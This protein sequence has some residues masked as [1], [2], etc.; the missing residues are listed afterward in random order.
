MSSN[1]TIRAEHRNVRPGTLL[2]DVP[3]GAAKTADVQLSVVIV[4]YNCLPLLQT[5][6]ASLAHEAG[7]P[8]FET[9]VVDNGSL[10]STPG[11]LRENC[12][13]VHVIRN[14]S[15]L[16][17]AK[18]CNQGIGAALGQYVL[19]LN[20]DTVASAGALRR[21]FEYMEA[22]PRLA[23]AS[24]KVLRP[25]GELDPSCKRG[26]PSAWD[27]FCRMTGV[28]RLLPNSRLF[29]RYD[30]GYMDENTRQE[31]PLIDGCFM[32][33]RQRALEDIGPFD[34]R[35][36][37][38]A[39]EMDWCRRARLKGWSIGYEPS[40]R[41]IHAKGEVTRHSTFRMLYHFHRS[42][43]L[44]YQKYHSPWN[45]LGLLVYPGVVLRFVL[46]VLWNLFRKNR[47]VSG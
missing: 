24:C 5:C 43:A 41:I 39:E 12:P 26:F 28:S 33:I 15:N 38:Y 22:N 14:G 19:L 9:I 6:L 44:Y 35:F 8:R 34:E 37:M 32:M 25:D 13:H 23:A 11:W 10:D 2:A 42:M 36:F 45:P 47:R 4:S 1:Q 31:V 3:R 30:G 18:G 16:G 29:A 20:P 27:A 17:F 21:T 40:G 46:L 7:P